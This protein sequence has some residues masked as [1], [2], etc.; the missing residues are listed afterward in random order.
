[1]AD[2]IFPATT[3]Y[4]RNDIAMVGDYSNHG[5]APIKQVVEKQF[6]AKDDYQIFSDLCIA[7][8]G[9]ELFNAYTENG[10][11]ELDWV[12]EF[13]NKAYNAVIKIPNL[14]TGMKPFK[15]FWG[16]NKPIFFNSTM[17]SE[18]FVKFKDFRE[19]PIL[20]ALGTP[21]GL[22]E[23]YSETIAKM[24]YDDCKA[25]PAWFEPAEWLGMK[26][27]PAEFHMISPHPA[28]R[29]HSQQNQTSLRD[30]Y[31]VA[32]HEPIYINSKDAAKKGIKNGDVVRI[33]NARGEALAGAI[34]T[35]DIKESVVKVFEGAWY[36]PS[37]PGIVGSICKNGSANL[38]TLDIPSSKLANANIAHTALVNIEKYKELAANCN[39]PQEKKTCR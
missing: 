5:I 11:K 36:D 16:I 31:A 27:K 18:S 35:D 34:V 33:F 7:Y 26:N 9:M 37:K 29:L 30:K 4:E 17:E 38:L 32:G 8:A 14:D 20:N 1:M 13:Y 21:S 19:D 22:I 25:H 15:E 2:I 23:I 28:D 10:K 12:E 39:Y 24:N 6:E 3:A